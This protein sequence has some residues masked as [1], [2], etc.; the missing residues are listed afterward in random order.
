MAN[1][2]LIYD[3]ECPLCLRAKDWIARNDPHHA[4]E[5]LPCQSDERPVK[6]PQISYD[7]CMESIQLVFPDGRVYS[8]ERAFER[9]LPFLPRWAW[10]GYGFK[11]P[12]M[13]FAAAP[14]YQWI[15]RHRLQV[16]GLFAHKKRGESCSVDKGCE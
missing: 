10:L 3:G 11:V 16:S 13:R 8:A 4:I 1:A 12:G 7:A 6:A 14:I 5:L 2:I 15:A 9:L